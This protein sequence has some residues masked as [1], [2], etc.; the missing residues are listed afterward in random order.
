MS[1]ENTHWN[2]QNTVE[3]IE[4]DL[5]LTSLELKAVAPSLSLAAFIWKFPSQA[6]M[7]FLMKM[8]MLESS[9]AD[10]KSPFS[11]WMEKDLAW[12]AEKIGF[13]LY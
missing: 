2:E 8:G 11:S 5:Q 10:L 12:K 7:M 13:N 3:M 4:P 9:W 6:F 1:R